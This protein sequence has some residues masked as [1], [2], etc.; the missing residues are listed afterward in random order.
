[1]AEW[2]AAISSS[3]TPLP[4]YP[5]PPVTKTRIATSARGSAAI[6]HGQREP[7]LVSGALRHAPGQRLVERREPRAADAGER[8]LRRTGRREAHVRRGPRLDQPLVE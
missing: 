1:M 7:P 8:A 6:V 2:P 3:M 4:M 5:A